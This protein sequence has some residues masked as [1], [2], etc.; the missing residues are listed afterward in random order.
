KHG[1]RVQ[2]LNCTIK[3]LK[4]IGV[5]CDSLWFKKSQITDCLEIENSTIDM[6]ETDHSKLH[7]NLIIKNSDVDFF[8]WA[9]S[10]DTVFSG[11]VKIESSKIGR[12]ILQSYDSQF[13]ILDSEFSAHIDEY[14][15]TNFS[16]F[17]KNSKV[18]FCL[19]N[20]STRVFSEFEF[21]NVGSIRFSYDGP[22]LQKV[23]FQDCERASYVIS[24]T[25]ENAVVFM[26][27]KSGEF[28]AVKNSRLDSLKVVGSDFYLIVDSNSM[29]NRA[30]F[31]ELTEFSLLLQNGHINYLDFGH[32]ESEIFGLYQDSTIRSLYCKSINFRQVLSL[33]NSEIQS[34]IVAR[35]LSTAIPKEKG[36]YVE[37]FKVK[38][39]QLNGTY[40]ENLDNFIFNA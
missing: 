39:L 15:G 20:Y 22:P 6:V 10:H 28:R 24:K 30:M 26:N 36:H 9:T 38:R 35:K 21:I 18:T 17:Q 27:V 37:N 33:A 7:K 13:E 40:Y 32:V 5:E 19:T 31:R 12:M 29:I 25:K 34:M 23:L 2:L 4:V 11:I 1:R 14:I 3:H 8:D 16:Y